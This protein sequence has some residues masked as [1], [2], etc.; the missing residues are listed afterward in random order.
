MKQT[1]MAL[2][3]A[4]LV[5]VIAPPVLYVAAAMEKTTMQTFML[6]GTLLWFVTVPLWMGRRSR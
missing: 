4:G 6:A 5:L 2:S 3:F 1:L